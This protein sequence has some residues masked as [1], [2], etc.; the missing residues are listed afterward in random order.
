MERGYEIWNLGHQESLQDGF[1]E[2]G[3]K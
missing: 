3:R 1:I 2:I